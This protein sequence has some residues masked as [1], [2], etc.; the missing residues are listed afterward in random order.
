MYNHERH[1]QRRIATLGVNAAPA[2]I[3]HQEGAL[4]LSASAGGSV[5]EE[6]D[7]DLDDMEDNLYLT[8]A[9]SN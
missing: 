9:R 1:R 2:P 3:E 6:H 4:S 8:R 5:M 7:Y